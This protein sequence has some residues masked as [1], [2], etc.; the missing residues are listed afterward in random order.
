MGV[1]IR[2]HH[3]GVMLVGNRC[4]NEQYLLQPNEPEV[5]AL[6]LGILARAVE[7]HGI[8]II[9][10]VFMGNHFHLLLIAPWGN[11]HAFMQDFE[12]WLAR[13]MHAY[14]G[15]SGP[16][17]AD[18]YTSIPLLDDAAAFEKLIYTLANPAAAGLVE[19]LEDYPGLSSLDHHF[20][21]E[22]IV[23]RWVDLGRYNKNRKRNP[24]YD[25]EKCATY[26]KFVLEPL[27]QMVGWTEERRAETIRTKLDHRCTMLDKERGGKPYLGPAGVRAITFT[28]R[29]EEP[30]N[31]PCPTCMGA[32]KEQVDLFNETLRTVSVA[33][34]K[35]NRRAR[36]PNLKEPVRY[37]PGTIP[38]N[39]RR[40]IPYE[41]RD[42]VG[43]PAQLDRLAEDAHRPAPPTKQAA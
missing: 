18:R 32:D 41:A 40:C 23:G 4:F 15:T 28:S 12:A 29:P 8:K 19:R 27:P 7:K 37:P 38:P 6:I 31:S 36:N 24:R 39:W 42:P 26:H 22:P 9:G 43:R 13:K 17:F 33:Y 35:A 25:E 30:K 16:F 1:R 5:S 10:F 3:T 14:R 21:H 11:L 2:V 34:R 20:N